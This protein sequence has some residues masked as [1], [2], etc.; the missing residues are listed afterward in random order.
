MR[1]RQC[2]RRDQGRAR[3]H[4]KNVQRPAIARRRYTSIRLIPKS[5]QP[6]TAQSATLHPRL[7][8]RI[9]SHA[10]MNRSIRAEL[11]RYIAPNGTGRSRRRA[12]GYRAPMRLAL[13]VTPCAI[14]ANEP[15]AASYSY[16]GTSHWSAHSFCSNGRSKGR[17]CEPL[18]ASECMPTLCRP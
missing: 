18:R 15:A 12:N 5:P 4:S 6:S 16:Q 17:E 7:C 1:D 2:L 3:G 9:R 8:P 10:H 11:S 13:P 14:N